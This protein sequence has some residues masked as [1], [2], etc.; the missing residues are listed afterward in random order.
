MLHNTCPHYPFSFSLS[1]V[2]FLT[3][4]SIQKHS[5]W[6]SYSHFQLFEDGDDQQHD[7]SL[8]IMAIIKGRIEE[9][10]FIQW[11]DKSMWCVDRKGT[12]EFVKNI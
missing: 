2:N 5:F 8:T 11:L 1:T 10:S 3:K 6:N 9:I 7:G 4:N 12:N